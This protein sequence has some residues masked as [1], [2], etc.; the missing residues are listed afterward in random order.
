MSEYQ[1]GRIPMCLN[2]NVSECRRVRNVRM[3]PCPDYTN[4]DVSEYRCV[5][6]KGGGN[7]AEGDRERV[8]PGPPYAHAALSLPPPGAAAV[9]VAAAEG[10]VAAAAPVF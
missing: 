9:A 2:T 6:E 3:P 1:C 7:E 5:G 4:T 10:V 8:A